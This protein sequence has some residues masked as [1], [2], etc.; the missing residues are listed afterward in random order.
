[1]ELSIH[2]AFHVLTGPIEIKGAMPGD[3]LELR[4]L[5]VTSER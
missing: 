3:V 2:P 1:V 5:E 4:I